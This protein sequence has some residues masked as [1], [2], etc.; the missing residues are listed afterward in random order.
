MKGDRWGAYNLGGRPGA[1]PPAGPGR[2]SRSAA[3]YSMRP[4]RVLLRRAAPCWGARGCHA[5]LQGR[6]GVHKTASRSACFRG[7]LPCMLKRGWLGG[8]GYG[9]SK[10]WGLCKSKAVGLLRSRPP[11][12]LA[13][14]GR[15]PR[16]LGLLRSRGLGAVT[17]QAAAEVWGYTWQRAIQEARQML[18][19]GPGARPK[20]G[21]RG[22]STAGER[23]HT[24]ATQ[25][26]RACGEA[27]RRRARLPGGS[28]RSV[29]GVWG[30]SGCS[31]CG[32]SGWCTRQPAAPPASGGSS[33]ACSN[34]VGW[35]G[36]DTALPKFGGYAS[37]WG[38]ASPRGQDRLQPLVYCAAGRRPL[39]P[40]PGG[41]LAALGC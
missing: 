14:P 15:P 36:W 41:R 37:L 34:V 7:L 30:F 28:R 13:Q 33:H 21:Q 1:R 16:G 2:R 38:R 32:P 26:P 27:V 35:A 11:T 9:P 6:A 10:V 20:G 5:G 8:V 19:P 40:S 22:P 24:R 23:T 18:G 3:L 12:A 4:P 39:W 25:P 17:A 29:V 31:G